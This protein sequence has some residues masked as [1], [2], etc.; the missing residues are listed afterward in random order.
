MAVPFD[1]TSTQVFSR[2]RRLRHERLHPIARRAALEIHAHAGAGRRVCVTALD[3]P[4]GFSPVRTTFWRNG[5]AGQILRQR[6]WHQAG[7]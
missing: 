5:H 1:N 3:K 7:Y 4:M 6:P 2:L